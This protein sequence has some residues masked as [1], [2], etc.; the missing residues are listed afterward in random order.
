MWWVI[1]AKKEETRLKRLNTLIEDSNHGRT[2]PQLTRRTKS[3]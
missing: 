1:N 3:E 2:L